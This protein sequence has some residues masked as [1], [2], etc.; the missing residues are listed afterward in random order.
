MKKVV[1]ILSVLGMIGA[2]VAFTGNNDSHQQDCKVEVLEDGSELV[3]CNDGSTK[4][5]AMGARH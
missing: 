2:G 3:R 4:L 1:G 5:I